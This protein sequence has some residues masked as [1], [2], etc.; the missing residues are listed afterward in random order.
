MPQTTKMKGT[1]ALA[2][3]S[4]KE[5]IDRRN[6]FLRKVVGMEEALQN[7]HMEKTKTQ[8]EKF[9]MMLKWI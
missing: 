4:K 8:Y 6:S 9:G 5:R 1:Q 2:F 3:S 7:F